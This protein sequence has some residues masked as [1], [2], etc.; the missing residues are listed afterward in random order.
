MGLQV[1][2][3]DGGY[4]AAGGFSVKQTVPLQGTMGLSETGS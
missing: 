2:A 1:L 4:L 3:V